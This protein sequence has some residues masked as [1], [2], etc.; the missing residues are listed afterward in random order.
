[1]SDEYHELF[2]FEST[3]WNAHVVM[4]DEVLMKIS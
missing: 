2:G 3:E 4:M 1:M